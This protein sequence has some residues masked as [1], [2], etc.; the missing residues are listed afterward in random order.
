M[1]SLKHSDIE[2]QRPAPTCI[3]IRNQVLSLVLVHE[4]PWDYLWHIYQ[5]TTRGWTSWTHWNWCLPTQMLL[6]SVRKSF[7]IEPKFFWFHL[8]SRAASGERTESLLRLRTAHRLVI[9]DNIHY[10]SGKHYLLRLSQR[11]KRT[12]K[13]VFSSLE[14]RWPV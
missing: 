5:S 2:P 14:R 4:G 10:G 13:S 9:I 6:P 8:Q 12:I 7:P 1:L 3:R 11:R